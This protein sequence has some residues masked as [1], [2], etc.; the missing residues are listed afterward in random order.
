[1]FVIINLQTWVLLFDYLGIGIP[2]PPPSRPSTPEPPHL[3]SNTDQDTTPQKNFDPQTFTQ[4]RSDSELN[5]ETQMTQSSLFTSAV[6][7]SILEDARDM[8]SIGSNGGVGMFSNSSQ[9]YPVREGGEASETERQSLRPDSLSFDSLA[10]FQDKNELDSQSGV[11]GVEGKTSM[12]IGLNVKS[13]TVTF[14]KQEHPLAKGNVS[15]VT[16]QVKTNKGNLEISGTLGQAS[17]M[18]LTETGAFYR[19][20]WV[21]QILP[22]MSLWVIFCSL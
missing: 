5:F 3:D 4:Y 18:D 1:M 17:V 7:Q 10:S 12:E 6:D 19:E 16:A 13:L 15:S 2:T 20:R 9:S 14:N 22:T 8:A 21:C 11:W